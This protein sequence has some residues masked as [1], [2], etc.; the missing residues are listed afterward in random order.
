M[1]RL[2]T[3]ITL[4]IIICMSLLIISC[5]ATAL[6][7]NI[8]ASSSQVATSSADNEHL[9]IIDMSGREITF[10]TNIERVV[11]IGSALRL[12]TYVNGID[13]LVGVERGQQDPSTGR[14]YIMA[15]PGLQ[16]LPVIGEGNPHSP[17][18]EL[19][20]GVNPDVII[21]GDIMDEASLRK[22]EAATGIPVVITSCGTEAIFDSKTDQALQI[23]GKITGQEQRSQD[24]I[25]FFAQHKQELSSRSAIAS[26][27][28]SKSLYIG[29][30]SFKGI[31]GIESTVANSPL[32]ET[33]EARNVVDSIGVTGNTTID[34]EQLLIWDPDIIVI[35]ANGLALVE[36]DYQ[37][38]PEF[39][40]SLSA[41]KNNEIYLQLPYIS[42]YSNLETA[43]INIYNLGMAIYPE[44]FEDIN[45]ALIA[46]E[47]YTFLLGKDLYEEMTELFGSP[48]V[49]RIK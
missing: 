11:A 18:P 4:L 1:N 42:Y 37:K 19:L 14:P 16:S 26:E 29:A 12:Y 9:T 21:A 31:H 10:D 3:V 36:E 28:D 35:D 15:N 33:I 46:E 45:G 25:S 2:K 7:T 8:T 38:I 32:V 41:F 20:I 39:Y 24:I 23:I 13:M 27:S 5:S 40:N 47:I 30:V 34:K 49:I 43:L 22:L 48:G 6:E 17:D 44:Q